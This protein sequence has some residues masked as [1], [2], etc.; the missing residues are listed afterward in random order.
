V[1]AL[2]QVLIDQRATPFN[3]TWSAGI[4]PLRLQQ[5]RCP[6]GHVVGYRRRP[7]L[8]R[9]WQVPSVPLS[10]IVSKLLPGPGRISGP[11]AKLPIHLLPIGS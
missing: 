8:G 5:G 4:D 1:E 3:K 7:G 6:M 11:K 9:Y 2:K 10:L